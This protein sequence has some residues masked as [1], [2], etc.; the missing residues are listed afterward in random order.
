MGGSGGIV[1]CLWWERPSPICWHLSR[2]EVAER[3]EEGD[4]ATIRKV[5]VARQHTCHIWGAEKMSMGL[6][7][8]GWEE[9]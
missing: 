9:Q 3:G 1:W 5:R 7:Q 8:S 2:D 4:H 6:K